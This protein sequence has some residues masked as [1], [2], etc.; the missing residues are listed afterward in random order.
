M[1]SGCRSA[2][3]RLVA[4]NNTGNESEEASMKKLLSGLALAGAICVAPAWAADAGFLGSLGDP[5]YYGQLDMGNAGRPPVINGQP[6]LVE[7]RY[8]NLAPIY[9]RAP[10]GQTKN[11]ARYCDRYNACTRPTYFVK[12]N[13]YRDVYAPGYRQAHDQANAGKGRHEGHEGHDGRDD[14]DKGNAH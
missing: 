14:H 9:V 1:L 10:P 8:H 11:W 4:A 2:D 7:H 3:I 5:G 6:V 12:D 13:W